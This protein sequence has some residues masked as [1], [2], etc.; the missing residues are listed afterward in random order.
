MARRARYE[1]RD[2]AGQPVMGADVFDDQ[3][4][5]EAARHSGTVVDTNTGETLYN[6]T[7]GSGLDST[8]L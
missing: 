3:L 7:P 4:K 6:A 1:V 2:S 8:I 5:F